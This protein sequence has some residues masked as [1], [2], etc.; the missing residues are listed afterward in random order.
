MRP[1]SQLR[2]ADR[3]AMAER[4]RQIADAHGFIAEIAPACLD[5]RG[6]NVCIR[7]R[8]GLNCSMT[9]TAKA[10]GRGGWGFLGHWHMDIR[11]TATL[12]LSFGADCNGSV[13]PYHRCKATTHGGDDFE[14]FVG[15]LDRA[16]EAVANDSAFAD[17]AEEIAA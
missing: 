5:L 16:L 9:F 13:N 12:C 11:A 15:I 17:E 8:R 7:A 14:V 4:V 10:V 2:A 1:L 6:L 3:A